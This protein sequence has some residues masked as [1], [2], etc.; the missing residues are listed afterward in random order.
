MTQI[1]VELGSDQGYNNRE[2]KGNMDEE[3]TSTKRAAIP[4]QLSK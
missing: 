1:C 2:K 3:Q 4:M